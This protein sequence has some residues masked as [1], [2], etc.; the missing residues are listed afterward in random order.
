MTK[1]DVGR[2]RFRNGVALAAF[3]IASSYV[4]WAMIGNWNMVE[5]DRANGINHEVLEREFPQFSDVRGRGADWLVEKEHRAAK[6]LTTASAGVALLNIIVMIPL[7]GMESLLANGG[8][9]LANRLRV[10]NLA[11]VVGYGIALL[12]VIS[13]VWH[14]APMRC[15]QWQRAGVFKNDAL[16]K[17]LGAIPVSA[18][19]L[20]AYLA[21][22]EWLIA[23][24]GAIAGLWLSARTLRELKSNRPHSAT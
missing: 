19:S 3:V 17:L 14:G 7:F 21:W 16:Q 6:C 23:L 4:S 15:M 11:A 8:R 9:S 20:A 10:I 2:I 24:G 13:L 1:E 22:K 5:V 12:Y 18:W